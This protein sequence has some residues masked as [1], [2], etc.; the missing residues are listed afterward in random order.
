M[1]LCSRQLAI[2]FGSSLETDVLSTSRCDLGSRVVIVLSQ[3]ELP[4]CQKLLAYFTG[5][6]LGRPNGKIQFRTTANPEEQDIKLR[7]LCSIPHPHRTEARH[8]FGFLLLFLF[9]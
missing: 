2:K 6:Q 9:V 5:V 1:V 4:F 3:K 8:S 7:G